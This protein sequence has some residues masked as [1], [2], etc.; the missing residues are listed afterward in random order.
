MDVFEWMAPVLIDI[1]KASPQ[2]E[3]EGVAERTGL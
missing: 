3:G 2:M 1:F